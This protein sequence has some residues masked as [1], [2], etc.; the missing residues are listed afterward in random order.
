MKSYYEILGIDKNVDSKAV[1]AAYRKLVKQFHPDASRSKGINSAKAFE[2]ITAAYSTLMNPD[3]RKDYDDSLKADKKSVNGFS[4][5]KFKEWKEWLKSWSFLKLVLIGRKT[6]KDNK[7]F[8]KTILD[9]PVDELLKR[10]LYSKNIHVQLHAVK[11]LLAK[12]KHYVVNDLLRLLYSNIHETV[13]LEIIQGLIRFPETKIK[14]VI[15]EIYDLEKSIK[16]R[17]MIRSMVRL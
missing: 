7:N 5:F 16:V 3:K 15:R 17:Q 9:I 12:R 10:V 4:A 13:K 14:Q 1:K 8:D 6:A 11:V 2:E